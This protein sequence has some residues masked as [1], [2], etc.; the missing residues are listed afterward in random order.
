MRK[1]D[2][3][4]RIFPKVYW[5]RLQTRA[6]RNIDIGQHVRSHPVL[7]DLGERFRIMDRFGDY[8]Q[9]LSL[10]SPPLETIFSPDTAPDMARIANDGLAELVNAYPHRFPGFIA[11]L[12]MARPDAAV[13]ETF[14]AVKQLGA[15]GVQIFS[16]VGGQPLDHEDFFPIFRAAYQ[17]DIA[18]ILQPASEAKHELSAAQGRLVFSGL[19]DTLAGIKIVTHHI[20]GMVPI[21]RSIVGPSALKRLKKPHA[22]YFKDFYADTAACLTSEAIRDGMEYHPRDRVLFAS[23][24]PFDPERS[25]RRIGELIRLVEESDIDADWKRDIF[26]RNAAKIMAFDRR[27]DEP[28]IKRYA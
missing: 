15:L 22:E 16:G 13:E 25:V 28:S 10:A 3:S 11:A 4:S 20:G 6:G 17:L 24:A 21:A 2:V 7:T 14:R 23:D 27:E 19:M 18:M 12:P 9:I 5:S 8:E 26:W 1:I